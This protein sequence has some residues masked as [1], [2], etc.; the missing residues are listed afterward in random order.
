[1]FSGKA[2]S[3]RFSRLTVYPAAVAILS[4]ALFSQVART[5]DDANAVPVRLIVVNSADEA[6]TVLDRLKA[7]DD[8]AVLAREKSVDATSVDGGFLGKV[9]P[10]TLR[11]ELRDALSGVQPGQ[12][13]KV[14][15][16]PSGYAVLEVLTETEAADLGSGDRAL[17]AAISAVGSVR[18]A[19]PVGGLDE[20]LSALFRNPLPE[21]WGD[22]PHGVCDAH[23]QSYAT[24][25]KQLEGIVDPANKE[26]PLRNK[27]TKPI[28]VMQLYV[29]KAQFHAYQG[30]MAKA[31]EL[32]EMAYRI[33]LSDVPRGVPVI[34][35]TLGIGYLHK[36]EM[37]NDVYRNPGER[38]IFPMRPE[39]RYAKTASS[40]KAI[41]YFLKYLEQ[42]PDDLEVKWLLNL[43]YMTLGSYP[44]G[45]P[46]KYL[47]PPSSFVSAEKIG[48]F[49]DVAPQAGLNLFAMASGVIVD[50][51]DND[52]QLDVV[53][54]TYDTCEPMHYFH[55]NGNGTFTDHGAQSGL[56]EQVGGLNLIQTD[57]NN[58]G[59]TDILVL[60]GAWEK[61]GHR[62][63]LLRNNC[64]G[65]FTD[66]T[67]ESGLAKPATNTQAGVWADIDNDGLLDLFVGNENGPSQL[68]RNKGDGTFEDISH[69]AG[70]DRITF[71]KG[72]VAADYDH[73]G[74]VD[75]YVSNLSSG[76]FLYHNNHNGTFTDIAKQAGVQGTG[77][78]FVSWFF[79]YDNDGWPDL[80]VTSYYTSVEETLQTYLGLPHKAGTLKLYK[81]LGNGAFRDVTKET[82]LDKVFMPMGAN[83]GDVDNDGYPDIYLGTGDPSY[84]SELPNVLLRNKEGKSFVDVTASS[85]TGEL[86]KGHGVA[87]A[88]MDNDGDEDIVTSIGGA[89]PGDRHAFRLFENPGNGNDWISLKLVGVK[90]NKAAIG[91]RIKVT[92]KDE[93]AKTRAIYRTVGSG[94]S[95]GASPLQ[96]HIGLGKSAQIL[97]IEIFWPDG[98][99][100]PQTFSNVAKNQFLEIKE[101]GTEYTKLERRPYRLGGAK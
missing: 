47:V 87:F 41:Q 79:D 20:V 75:F 51:F 95:F 64:N 48:R 26:S 9:D 43:A 82:A 7:G 80:F 63:S 37:D 73:D 58:D 96:Q 57:Y 19:P 53:T 68:F 3:A 86:H 76:N 70:I 17:Q 25:M 15:K 60:R 99:K 62:K 55:N 2:N 98:S 22:D 97:S 84:A 46:Q 18:Y 4:L 32:W 50:D 85:G 66:V 38:C 23:R 77:R 71:A 5:G 74:Y 45:V 24:V 44:A 42:K 92:I 29:A 52:G 35:E 83:F 34:E 88:D 14:V 49:T 101:F 31:I 6:Q 94:G 67:K 28:D 40:E 90:A 72:V 21:G 16:I 61:A 8:F 81:N 89:T 27:N 13:S 100:T 30:E 78:T 56:S 1:M 39:L 59:C 33:A 36:S 10:A 12:L 54:S 65:T 11:A 69:S 91:A 93:D